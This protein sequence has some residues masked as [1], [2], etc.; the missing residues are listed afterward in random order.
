MKTDSRGNNCRVLG[1]NADEADFVKQASPMD[2]KRAEIYNS[3]EYKT[4]LNAG[5]SGPRQTATT[6]AR[7]FGNVRPLGGR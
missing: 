1:T 3:P 5:F 2:T 6:K 4:D 7:R